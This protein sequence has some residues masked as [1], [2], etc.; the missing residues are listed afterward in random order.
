MS[1]RSSKQGLEKIRVNVSEFPDGSIVEYFA[2]V[3]RRERF[4]RVEDKCTLWCIYQAGV[5]V[6]YGVQSLCCT[7][8]ISQHQSR[9]AGASSGDFFR[10]RINIQDVRECGQISISIH[11][12]PYASQVCTLRYLLRLSRLKLQILRKSSTTPAP[13][14]TGAAAEFVILSK[15]LLPVIY[16]ISRYCLRSQHPTVS[17]LHHWV[18]RR[19]SQ[20]RKSQKSQIRQSYETLLTTIMRTL[21]APYKTSSSDAIAPIVKNALMGRRQ[22]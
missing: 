17:P 1:L 7:F 18:A 11:R 14:T 9:I 20:H 16:G 22:K 5:V 6:K 12:Y 19:H 2:S 3:E 10:H 15:E 13:I 8:N 21:R 4:V